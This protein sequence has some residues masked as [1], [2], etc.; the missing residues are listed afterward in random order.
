MRFER[1]ENVFSIQ[2]FEFQSPW[3]EGVNTKPKL[4]VIFVFRTI[5]SSKLQS[6]Y[7]YAIDFKFSGNQGVKPA[8]DTPLI[9]SSQDNFN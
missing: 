4:N 7:F 8:K 5:N 3:S 9:G 2:V 6:F 1:R